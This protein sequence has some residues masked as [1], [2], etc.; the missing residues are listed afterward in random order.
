MGASATVWMPWSSQPLR[1]WWHWWQSWCCAPITL[2][3]IIWWQWGQMGWNC[4]WL[5]L[6]PA[7]LQCPASFLLS[8]SWPKL[9][10]SHHLAVTG[11][12]ADHGNK[13]G[14]RKLKGV[15]AGGME[16]GQPGPIASMYPLVMVWMISHL[17]S[18]RLTGFTLSCAYLLTQAM[19]PDN[20]NVAF[21]T[22][23]KLSPSPNDCHP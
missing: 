6:S 5:L 3:S 10:T 22:S 9:G 18:P 21:L 1:H 20:V 2:K 11:R 23:P 14:L 4:P 13:S 12:L 17:P 19:T 8:C 15:N 16:W 7:S